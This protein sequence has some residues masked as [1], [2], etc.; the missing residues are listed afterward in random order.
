MPSTFFGLS[1][2]TSGMLSYRAHLNVTA[3]NIANTK[4][5]GYTRQYAEQSAKY[6]ISLKTSYGM[7]G[8]GSEVTAIVNKRDEY[9]DYKFRKSNATFGYYD[10]A[11]YYMKSLEDHMY[12]QDSE[13]AGLSNSLTNFFNRLTSLTT[14]VSDITKRTEITGYADTFAKYANEMVRNFQQMQDELNMHI[15]TTVDQVNAYAEQIASLTK[16]I[17]TLEVYGGRANDLRDQRERIID[18]LSLL[19]NVDV[20]EIPAAGNNGHTQYIVNV[21][22]GVLV[23]TNSYNK[24]SVVPSDS[25]NNLGDVDGLYTIKWSNGQKFPIRNTNLGGQLQALFEIRDGNNGENFKATYD[26]CN[27]TDKTITMSADPSSSSTAS[28]LAKLSIPAS[29]G[30]IKVGNYEYQYDSFEVNVDSSGKYTYTFKLKEFSQF[31]VKNI[32]NMAASATAAGKPLTTSIGDDVE[33]RGIPYYISQLNEF[34]RTFSATFNQQHNK[35]YDMDGNLGQDLFMA[36]DTTTGTQLD[37]TEF[38]KNTKDGYYYLNGN[39]VFIAGTVGTNDTNTWE[40]YKNGPLATNGY[41]YKQP[42][43][44]N[45]AYP[46]NPPDPSVLPEIPETVTI[47][48]ITYDCYNINDKDGKFVEKVYVSQS[49]SIFSFKSSVSATEKASYYN[50]TASNY[51]AN[52]EM[53]KNGRMIAAASKDPRGLVTGTVENSGIEQ[54]A[55]LEL[56]AA[57]SEDKTMFKQGEPL[58]F[59]QVMTATIGVDSDKM[60]DCADNA[61]AITEAVDIR[62]LATS[63]VDEDEEGQAFIELQ[64]LLNIQYRVVSIMNQVLS[65]LINEMGL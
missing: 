43:V 49:N 56:L 65:K 47:G 63:G 32:T 4:T 52:Q 21:A 25:Y 62:R 17:N 2:A 29:D 34:V 46:P 5:S 27:L 50:L 59:L 35:G 57:L 36:K 42:Q 51:S 12:S 58:G 41:T 13:S 28:S 54:S 9:Y 20:E 14:T 18:D 31:D 39:K 64:N 40:G 61:Q 11:Q 53:V 22:G 10:T 19:V 60:I 3:H 24:L 55:N 15:S 7:V 16:Q 38:L 30:I 26:S 45:P 48:G 44:P 8:A 1:I 37:M 33:Y 23:D 6:P